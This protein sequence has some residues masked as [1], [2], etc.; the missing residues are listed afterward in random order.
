[1]AQAVICIAD[2]LSERGIIESNV[3]QRDVCDLAPGGHQIETPDTMSIGVS[4]I[5]LSHL[6][7]SVVHRNG[8]EAPHL[9]L[10][11][12]AGLEPASRDTAAV[13]ENRVVEIEQHRL[14]K[15]YQDL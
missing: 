9:L 14:G 3:P 5:P 13:V 12:T 1:V 2:L 6:F 7:D 11:G 4:P 10:V 15:W 8:I